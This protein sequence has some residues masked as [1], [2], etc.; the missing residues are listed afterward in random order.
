MRSKSLCRWWC[1]EVRGMPNSKVRVGMIFL[2]T[3]S[4]TA[5]WNSDNNEVSNSA[6]LTS[7]TFYIHSFFYFTIE[8]VSCLKNVSKIKFVFSKYLWLGLN[9]TSH[10]IESNDK[11]CNRKKVGF[12]PILLWFYTL[13]VPIS[14]PILPLLEKPRTK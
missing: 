13:Y 3:I 6:N 9:L 1:K 10:V 14:T 11:D 5:A 4:A 7:E 12:S 2:P 8:C